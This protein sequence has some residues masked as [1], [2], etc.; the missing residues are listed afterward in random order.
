MPSITR[1]I[2][3]ETFLERAERGKKFGVYVGI[4]T[5]NKDPDGKYRVRVR[6]PSQANGD[7]SGQTSESTFWYRIGTFG[8]GDNRGM[9]NLPEVNDEVLIAFEN[10]EVSHGYVICSLWNEKQKTIDKNSDGKN[11]VRWY[12][13]R[14]GHMLKFVDDPSKKS[15]LIQTKT[16]HII[17]LD[18]D[19][20]K[21]I[22]IQHHSKKTKVTMLEKDIEVESEGDTSFKCKNFKV[23]ANANIELTSTQD[24]KITAS[25]NIKGQASA[26]VELNASGQGK[27]T[28]SGPITI[29]G[30]VVNIN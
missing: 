19:E 16:G 22:Y 3:N 30:A 5:D 13:S 26:N 2:A 8:A 21:K 15:I 28:A 23:N 24:T 20:G 12:Q 25:A 4:V 11:H 1:N 27:F 6:I 10:G 29:K 18:D 14:S 7:A 9:Y 17:L